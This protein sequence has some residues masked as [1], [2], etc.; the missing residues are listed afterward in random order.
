VKKEDSTA[1]LNKYAKFAYNE[2]VDFGGD[3]IRMSS[4]V[5]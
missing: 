5:M 1:K 2:E 3:C 4:V